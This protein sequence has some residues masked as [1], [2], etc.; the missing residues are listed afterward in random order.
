MVDIN[1]DNLRDAN[2]GAYRLIMSDYG[3]MYADL[4]ADGLG[5]MTCSAVTRKYQAEF[6]LPLIDGVNSEDG[7][8]SVNTKFNINIYENTQIF[9][10]IG[11][12]GA[13]NDA[14]AANI[15]LDTA[16]GELYTFDPATALLTGLSIIF[17]SPSRFLRAPG[18]KVPN[19]RYKLY[20]L[21]LNSG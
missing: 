4:K 18:R 9:M 17:L 7:L 5:R 8:L 20:H 10:G 16:T 19:I 6:L 21:G 2:E 11:N 1:G 15:G 13:L 12:I 3:S 14:P